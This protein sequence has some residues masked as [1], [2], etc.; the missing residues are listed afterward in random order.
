[1]HVFRGRRVVSERQNGAGLGV[2]SDLTV[3]PRAVLVSLLLLVA[4][5]V[6][7]LAVLGTWW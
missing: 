6:G 3:H 1:M 2:F 7:A 4:L 5:V